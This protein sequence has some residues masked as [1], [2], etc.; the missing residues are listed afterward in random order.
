[1]FC[2]GPSVDIR[3]KYVHLLRTELLQGQQDI[4]SFV[5]DEGKKKLRDFR[6][7][8]HISSSFHI[9]AL[10]SLGWSLDQYEAGNKDLNAIRKPIVIPID[11][12]PHYEVADSANAINSDSK[13]NKDKKSIPACYII[14]LYSS[15]CTRKFTPIIPKLTNPRVLLVNNLLNNNLRSESI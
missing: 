13:N 1:M 6:S 12:P 15:G 4:H 14:L 7:A 8:H 11:L 5:S 2:S 10:R 3:E 9:Q